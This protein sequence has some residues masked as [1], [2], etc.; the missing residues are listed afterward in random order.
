MREHVDELSDLERK[1]RVRL[2]LDDGTTV[3]GRVNQFD[4]TPDERLRLELAV[5]DEDGRY[6]IRSRY[7]DDE[8]TPVEVRRTTADRDDW[9]TLGRVTDVE[10]LEVSDWPESG[11]DASYRG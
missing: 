7:E 11:E 10:A 5:E 9:E 2:T 8:W 3:E 6:Q 4:Y 1:Q